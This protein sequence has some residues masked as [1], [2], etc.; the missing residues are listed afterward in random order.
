MNL[1]ILS[2]SLINIIRI[3]CLPDATHTGQAR[4]Q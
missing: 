3:Q 1:M 2:D 4:E